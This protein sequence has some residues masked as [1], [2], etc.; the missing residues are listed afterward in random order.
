MKGDKDD[1]K[2]I[3]PDNVVVITGSSNGIGKATAEYFLER[4]YEVHGI[5]NQPA[6]SN[7]TKYKNFH[8]HN[9]DLRCISKYPDIENV[10]IL[11]NN[12]G[13]QDK[14]AVEVNLLGTIY[15]TRKYGLQPAI[16]SICNLASVSAHN[17]A[18]FDL[19]TASK[20][21][22]LSY[23]VWTAKEIARYG[24]TCNSIS[25]GGVYTDLNQS[26]I[27]DNEAWKEI[28]DMTPLRKWATPEECAEWIYFLTEINQSCTGQDI[29]IDNGEF[30]NHTFVW[31]EK[32][33]D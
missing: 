13:V 16:K 7:L 21:G 2:E 32:G 11:I 28:M 33:D 8:E 3:Y 5:D 9:I 4:F 22:I 18:E 6:P 27:N 31:R 25:F 23:T 15:C 12:A 30:Y 19:Y 24:A 1:M 26:V 20:G 10:N 14:T 17:G 29:I